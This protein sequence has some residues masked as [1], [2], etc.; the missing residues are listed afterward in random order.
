MAYSGYIIPSKS[1]L[2]LYFIETVYVLS[3]IFLFYFLL[4]FHSIGLH[5]I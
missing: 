4:K 5:Y 2:A 1:V 3:F